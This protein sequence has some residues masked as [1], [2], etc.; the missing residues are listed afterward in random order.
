VLHKVQLIIVWSI[1]CSSRIEY[2]C[3]ISCLFRCLLTV[4]DTFVFICITKFIL[5]KTCIARARLLVD[6]MFSAHD[7]GYVESAFRNAAQV[8]PARPSVL[9]C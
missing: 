9:M 5:V 2:Q 8:H 1:I 4:I 6:N 7:D 3:L